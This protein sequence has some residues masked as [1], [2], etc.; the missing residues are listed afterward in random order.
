MLNENLT[1]SADTASLLL[2][3]LRESLK[4]ANPVEA[5]VLLDAIASAAQLAN[6]IAAIRDAVRSN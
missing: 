3:D 6:R 5:I 1:K 4:H 2:S